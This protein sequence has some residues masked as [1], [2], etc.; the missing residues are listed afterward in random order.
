LGIAYRHISVKFPQK[1]RKPSQ[2][3]ALPASVKTMAD[4]IHV[5]LLDHGMA[6]YHLAFKMG[7]AS[8]LVNGWKDGTARPRVCHIRE[9][10]RH[11]GKYCRADNI[12]QVSSKI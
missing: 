4:W 6:P 10:V 12:D 7:I 3:K 5:K 11:L 1:T 2:P 9:M 8:A